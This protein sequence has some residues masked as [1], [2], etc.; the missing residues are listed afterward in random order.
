ME[1]RRVGRTKRMPGEQSQDVGL[2][3]LEEI[4]RRVTRCGP[5]S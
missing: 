5:V 4:K 3:V 2:S 1:E